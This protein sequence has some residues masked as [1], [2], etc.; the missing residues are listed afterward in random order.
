MNSRNYAGFVNATDP[1]KQA[2][3]DGVTAKLQLRYDNAI[4]GEL[5]LPE[6]T[7]D[8]AKAIAR[9]WLLAPT[10]AVTR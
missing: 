10:N 1:R 7:R 4:V 2:F 9:E 3:W 6:A 5:P 8:A